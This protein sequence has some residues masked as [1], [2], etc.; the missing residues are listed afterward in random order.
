VQAAK[1][2]ARVAARMELLSMGDPRVGLVAPS[3]SRRRVDVIGAFSSSRARQSLDSPASRSGMV[4]R[5]RAVNEGALLGIGEAEWAAR[6]RPQGHVIGP[7]YC[8]Q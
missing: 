5:T 7:C 4:S 3:P 6:M 1:A 8:A 2:V